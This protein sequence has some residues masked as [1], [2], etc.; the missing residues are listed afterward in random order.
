MFYIRVLEDRL[1]RTAIKKF[2]PMQQGDVRSTLSNCELLRALTGFVPTTDISEG[3]KEFVDWYLE[4][5][6]VNI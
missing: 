2:M 3:I 4:Y 6:D 5:Y 1:G